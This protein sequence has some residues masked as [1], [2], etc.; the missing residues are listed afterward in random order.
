[1]T[2]LAISKEFHGTQVLYYDKTR[3]L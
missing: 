1:M 2:V 3:L